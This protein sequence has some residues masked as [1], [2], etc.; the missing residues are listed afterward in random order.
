MRFPNASV[1]EQIRRLF[2]AVTP[3]E[4]TFEKVED[5]PN[6][7]NEVSLSI[8]WLSE[9]I[10]ASETDLRLGN[11]KKTFLKLFKL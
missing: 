8:Q 9:E 1:G 7:L 10:A 4:T 2:Y 5:V 3:K 6:Y 11:R